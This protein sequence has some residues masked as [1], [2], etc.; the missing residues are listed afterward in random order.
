MLRF[1][2]IAR[3][4]LFFFNNRFVERTLS[5]FE[6]AAIFPQGCGGL[7]ALFF[8][9]SHWPSLPA[10]TSQGGVAGST[11]VVATGGCCGSSLW[12][13]MWKPS[14]HQLSTSNW[15]RTS[16][17]I[18]PDCATQLSHRR[19][20]RVERLFAPASVFFVML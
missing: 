12:Q 18:T 10:L 1:E 7:G 16:F 2:A 17:D 13:P 9:P 19:G 8:F 6:M 15:H 14:F 5:S 3:P 20:K 4:D 11:P